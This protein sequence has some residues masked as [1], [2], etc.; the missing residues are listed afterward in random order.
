MALLLETGKGP[1]WTRAILC[2][3]RD[4]LLTEGLLRAQANVLVTTL[5]KSVRIIYKFI[6][7]IYINIIYILFLQPQPV[8]MSLLMAGEY[9]RMW[10]KD[11]NDFH[12]QLHKSKK[13]AIENDFEWWLKLRKTNKCFCVI[14]ENN[15]M[16]P[17]CLTKAVRATC[18]VHLLTGKV[19]LHFLCLRKA[20]ARSSALFL[21]EFYTG[22]L[23][24][25][26]THLMR[27]SFDHWNFDL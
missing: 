15:R 26:D 27:A 4:H 22:F 13:L 9:Q 19:K 6:K 8:S 7:N 10:L 18:C 21:S 3:P 24:I 5:E 17:Q 2:R 23:F 20:L 25:E 1:E 11:R 12:K 14:W 16:V